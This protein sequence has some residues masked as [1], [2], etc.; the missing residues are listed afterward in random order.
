MVEQ[1]NSVE[2]QGGTVEQ[3]GIAW[4]GVVEHCGMVWWNSGTVW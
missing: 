4:H 2:Q 1:G 3:S